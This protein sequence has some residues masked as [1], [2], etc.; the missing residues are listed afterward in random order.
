MDL[1]VFIYTRE[2]RPSG[3]AIVELKSEDEV[4]L[5]LKT[6]EEK[7]WDTDLLKYSSQTTLKWIGC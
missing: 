5:A 3:K 2:A 4:K 6:K 7:L 1:K